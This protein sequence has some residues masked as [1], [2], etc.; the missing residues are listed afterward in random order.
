MSEYCVVMTTFNKKEDMELLVDLSIKEKLVA[1]VQ[2]MN[3]NSHYLWDGKVVHDEEIL[4]L[5]KTTWKSYEALEL[6]IKENHPYDTP[7]IIAL[8]IERGGMDYLKWIDSV[9]I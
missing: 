9:T 4:V 3:I 8:D 2:T 6:L 7:E 5:F 1:C